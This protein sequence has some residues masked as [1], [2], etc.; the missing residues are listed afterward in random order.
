MSHDETALMNNIEDKYWAF[1]NL[2]HSWEKDTLELWAL[3]MFLRKCLKKEKK[4]KK[5]PEWF[6]LNWENVFFQLDYLIKC[7]QM[8]WVSANQQW[9]MC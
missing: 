5:R 3:K 6:E 8:V 4:K 9:S 1:V 7:I 2:K